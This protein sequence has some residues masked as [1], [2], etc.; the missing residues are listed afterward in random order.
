MTNQFKSMMK[1]YFLINSQALT[2]KIKNLYK[3]KNLINKF[4]LSNQANK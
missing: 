3:I 1:A 2:K 4:K